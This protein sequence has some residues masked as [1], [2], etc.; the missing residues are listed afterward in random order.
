MLTA[1]LAV[2]SFVMIALVLKPL[3]SKTYVPFDPRSEKEV[4]LERLVIKKNKL[5]GDIKDLDLE[6][7]MGKMNDVDYHALRKQSLAEV[8]AVMKKLD[9][10]GHEVHGNGKV[11]D[12][13][14]EQLIRSIRR[15]IEVEKETTGQIC[16]ICNHQN[17][18]SS[19]FCAQCGSK[20]N[21]DQS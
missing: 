8:S 20:L 16:A 7:R 17:E 11:T 21:D 18:A 2:F 1:L 19:R 9:A 15:V 10:L 5:Y 14:R 3:F 6:Y 13:H 12:Q 4:E